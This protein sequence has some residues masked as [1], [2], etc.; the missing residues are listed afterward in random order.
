M[1][2]SSSP[3]D[4]AADG[5]TSLSPYDLVLAFA[6]NI[7]DLQSHLNGEAVPQELPPFK[8]ILAVWIKIAE[9]MNERR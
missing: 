9:K 8:C 2:A 4:D 7:S 1:S 5:G 6:N 3:N